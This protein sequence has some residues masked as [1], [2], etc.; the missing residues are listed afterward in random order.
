MGEN[1]D[2]LVNNLYNLIDLR[3]YAIVS[4]CRMSLPKGGK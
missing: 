1:K 3:N 2:E 4:V